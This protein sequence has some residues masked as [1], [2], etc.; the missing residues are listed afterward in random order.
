MVRLLLD[1][2]LFRR[3]RDDPRTKVRNL[4]AD[5]VSCVVCGGA[6]PRARA[7]TRG[8]AGRATRARGR[9]RGVPV[10]YIL[11]IAMF[12]GVGFLGNSL[13][14]G[15]TRSLHTR[16]PISTEGARYS[17]RQRK[18]EDTHDPDTSA[19]TQNTRLAALTRLTTVRR[20]ACVARAYGPASHS[21][22]SPPLARP[23]SLLRLRA[24]AHVRH[25]KR[26]SPSPRASRS[27]LPPAYGCTFVVHIESSR[28][29]SCGRGRIAVSPL[30]YVYV[31]RQPACSLSLS[32]KFARAPDAERPPNHR[33]ASTGGQQRSVAGRPGGG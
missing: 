25:G 21:G 15:R 1:D 5:A 3:V 18:R 7:G 30:F 14:C 16:R 17:Y 22:A 33:R 32:R 2:D 19:A 28:D 26:A 24:H 10:R 13:R 23:G 27:P 12:K 8:G 29:A 20:E 9:G 11:H 31:R 4:I 6:R